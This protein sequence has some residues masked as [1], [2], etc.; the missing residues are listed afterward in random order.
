MLFL[1]LI[2]NLKTFVSTIRD[3]SLSYVER[4]EKIQNKLEM[5]PGHLPVTTYV[6][7]S[8][9][10]SFK[11]IISNTSVTKN[12]ILAKYS[13]VINTTHFDD[14]DKVFYKVIDIDIDKKYNIIG[15]RIQ[16]GKLLHGQKP[17]SDWVF[18]VDI[19]KYMNI[20]TYEM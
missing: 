18:M 19:L 8:N 5:P 2:Q 3:I 4:Y 9:Y 1:Q 6:L 7:P 14:E 13:I 11:P 20:T 10:L 16:I 12:T 15:K 17:I